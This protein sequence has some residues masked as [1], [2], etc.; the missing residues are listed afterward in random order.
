MKLKSGDMLIMDVGNGAMRLQIIGRND[1]PRVEKEGRGWNDGAT[2]L[3]TGADVA[4]FLGVISG[5][6]GGRE[7]GD[8]KL[9][10][11]FEYDDISERSV[12][13]LSVKGVSVRLAWS[14]RMLLVHAIRGLAW[15]VFQ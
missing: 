13:V 4:E 5:S 1:V 2:A 15:K 11:E 6:S 9:S 10:V 8:S 14:E 7:I 3:L 12:L